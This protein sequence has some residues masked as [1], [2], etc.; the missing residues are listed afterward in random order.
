MTLSICIPTYNRSAHLA[1][2]LQAAVVS[3]RRAGGSVEICVSD[4]CST[5]D[6]PEVVRA[7]QAAWP[8]RYQRTAKNIGAAANFLEAVGM[9]RGEFVWLIGDDDLLLP[10][11]ASTMVSLIEAH[12]GIDYFF[13]NAWRLSSSLVPSYPAPLELDAVRERLEAVSPQ[14]EDR[15]LAFLS[16][17]D[18]AVSFDFLL[19]IFL[20]VF[21]R[22]G[23]NAHTGVLDRDGLFDTRLGAHFDNTCPHAKIFAHAF[24]RSRAR[25]HA[26]P[27]SVTLHGAREWSPLYPLVRSVRLVE[28]VDE[29]R[30]Q[31]LPWR[32]YWRCRNYAL[33][34][35]LPD[36]G[37]M[38]ANRPRAGL[39]YVKV[40]RL[41]LANCLYPNFYASVIYYIVRKL[42]GPGPAGAPAAAT[43]Q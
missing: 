21:R 19:G 41:L 22:T 6:T 1:R 39:H 29:Y 24:A 34:D 20:S 17:V 30:R 8:L 33:R 38:I 5:D 25:I 4:N 7:A 9:A 11:S 35:F 14:R 37:Y 26:A 40:W 2:C 23:W 28:L 43:G 42:S 32:Q 13:V 3:A 10:E 12:P 15:E 31:G 16:L 36:L 18:P 27:L